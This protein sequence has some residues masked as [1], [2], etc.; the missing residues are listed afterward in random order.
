MVRKM[1]SNLTTFSASNGEA[2][3]GAYKVIP[4]HP[5]TP[6][7]F[8]DTLDEANESDAVVNGDAYVVFDDSNTEITS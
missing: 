6:I 5:L 1:K 2:H 8:Y 7:T 3:M 4:R